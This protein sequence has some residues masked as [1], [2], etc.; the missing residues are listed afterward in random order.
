M[1][2]T[3][4]VLLVMTLIFGTLSVCPAFAAEEGGSW[5]DIISIDFTTDFDLSNISGTL[6]K[7]KS[8]LFGIV[9]G[10]RD[11]VMANETYKNIVTAIGAILAFICLPII[12][13]I[14]I[15]AY[16]SI[17][18]MIVVAGALVAVVEIFISIFS[19]FIPL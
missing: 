8:E 3:F 7:L 15:V 12:I 9:K 14:I 4:A 6:E 19:G 18:A 2:K 5:S 1:K 10:I 13:G 17:G 16:I 11:K